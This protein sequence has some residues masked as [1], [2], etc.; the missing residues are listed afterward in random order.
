MN[1][2]AK[3]ISM[4]PVHDKCKLCKF[5]PE[6]CVGKRAYQEWG[7]KCFRTKNDPK[8]GRILPGNVLDE[9]KGTG[10]QIGG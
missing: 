8:A 5:Y 4:S 1:I 3:S 10:I 6:V 9:L 2:S 7:C